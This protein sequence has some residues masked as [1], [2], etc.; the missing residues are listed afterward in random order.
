MLCC[1][2]RSQDFRGS[3]DPLRISLHDTFETW[4]MGHGECYC[5][6]F[7]GSRRGL[8]EAEWMIF[9]VMD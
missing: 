4:G 1:A 5:F 8:G 7:G 2:C 9:G 3:D 6:I